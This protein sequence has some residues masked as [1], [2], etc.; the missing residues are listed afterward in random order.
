LAAVR[1]L[2]HF[3]FW[4]ARTYVRGAKPADTLVF[5]PMLLPTTSPVPPQTKAK[6]KELEESLSSRDAQLAELIAGSAALDAELQRLR[7]EVAEAKRRNEAV[8]DTHNYSEEQTRDEFIDLL[9]DE[10]GWPLDQPQDREYEVS[11]MP[12]NPAWVMWTTCSGAEMAVLWESWRRNARAEVRR[13]GS[14]RRS[15]TP[16]VWRR[17][18]AN[19][20]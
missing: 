7:A 10:A 6:L 8:P 9:L 5:L 11:G 2:F 14:S 16:T 4:M 15:F 13:R 1:E 18:S 20:R 19:A 17:S 3:T 12:S